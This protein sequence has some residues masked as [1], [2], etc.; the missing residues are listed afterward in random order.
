MSRPDSTTE[1]K[2]WL[3]GHFCRALRIASILSATLRI[4]AGITWLYM[5]AVVLMFE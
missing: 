3:Q 4:I 2:S 5:S 1:S